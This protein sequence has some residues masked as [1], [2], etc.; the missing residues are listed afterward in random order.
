M[1]E[2][3]D[4]NSTFSQMDSAAVLNLEAIERLNSIGV[5]RWIEAIIAFSNKHKVTIEAC[6]YVVALQANCVANLFGPARVVSTL[7]PYFCSSCNV[8]HTVLVTADE[9]AAAGGIPTRQ[10]ES[11]GAEMAFDEL[12]NYFDFLFRDQ[13]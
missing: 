11:C 10:C 6:S 12:D 8:N 3:S 13:P 2:E 4:F 5:H 9:A 1:D 7:A